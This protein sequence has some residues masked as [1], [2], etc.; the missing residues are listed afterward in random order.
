MFTM[1]STHKR[2]ISTKY[3]AVGNRLETFQCPNYAN[4]EDGFCNSCYYKMDHSDSANDEEIEYHTTY[5]RTVHDKG[6]SN[7]TM[8]YVSR[9]LPRISHFDRKMSKKS[10]RRTIAVEYR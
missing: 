3:V 9:G 10:G 8:D 7:L 1:H 6:E 5:Q 2:C 4:D